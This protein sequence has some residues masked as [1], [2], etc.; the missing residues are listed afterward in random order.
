[1]CAIYLDTDREREIAS[2]IRYPFP[3]LKE[4]HCIIHKE[5][6]ESL[7]VEKG[8]QMFIEMD[9][10]NNLNQLIKRYSEETGLDFNLVSLSS[11]YEN[12]KISCTVDD[13]AE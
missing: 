12:F 11:K 2:G 6:A 5:M 9:V 4:G 13:F 1:M 8:D 3:K 7:R 10:R